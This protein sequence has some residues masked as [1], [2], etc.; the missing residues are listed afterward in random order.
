MLVDGIFKAKIS[1]FPNLC[2]VIRMWSRIWSTRTNNGS[3]SYKQLYLILIFPNLYL[4]LVNRIYFLLVQTWEKIIFLFFFPSRGFNVICMLDYKEYFNVSFSCFHK[5]Q[6]WQWYL[7]ISRWKTSLSQCNVD[8]KYSYDPSLCDL[9]C[10][11]FHRI[12]IIIIM[13]YQSENR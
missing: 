8:V 7:K 1:I 13:I 3:V 12:I 11:K 2:G 10:T 4:Y 5:L 6:L 9:S